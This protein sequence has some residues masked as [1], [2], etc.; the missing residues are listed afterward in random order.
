MRC[1]ADALGLG[2][3]QQRAAKTQQRAAR[4]TPARR[5]ALKPGARGV[6]SLAKGEAIGSGSRLAIIPA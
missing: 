6:A 2:R 4:Y 5:V 3:S 1:K